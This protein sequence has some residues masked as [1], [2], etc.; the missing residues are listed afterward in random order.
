LTGET[1]IGQIHDFFG[2]NAD[3]CSLKQD[4][5]VQATIFYRKFRLRKWLRGQRQ[6]LPWE[7]QMDG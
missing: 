1:R 5:V 7:L 3:S 2:Q 4:C 6:R